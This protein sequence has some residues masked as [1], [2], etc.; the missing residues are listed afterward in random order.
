MP[1]L[2]ARSIKASA[3]IPI[4]NSGRPQK[5]SFIGAHRQ[6]A[7]IHSREG[8]TARRLI[9]FGIIALSNLPLQTPK[10]EVSFVHTRTPQ[11]PKSCDRQ[12][13][14]YHGRTAMKA[15]DPTQF[16]FVL[17]RDFHIPPSVH[18]YEHQNHPAVDGTHD[19]LRLNLYMTKDGN[20]VTIWHGFLETFGVEFE[21]REGR[22][23]TAIKPS[24]GNFLEGFG[25]Q[26]LFRGY[27]D[28]PEAAEHIFKALR[29]GNSGKHYSLP[30][31]LSIGTDNKIRCDFLAGQAVQSA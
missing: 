14:A 19:F 13:M 26:D 29:I 28:S 20:Y 5:S 8:D 7:V 12:R 21:L 4:S 23:A 2:A 22:L 6:L 17:L 27:I 31:E 3:E 30:Q 9:F 25:G 24:D 15:F 1:S 16:N 11:F 10:Q 18:V